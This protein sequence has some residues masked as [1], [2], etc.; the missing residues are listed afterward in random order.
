MADGAGL[1]TDDD[2]LAER[3]VLEVLREPGGN[4]P[5]ARGRAMGSSAKA[6]DAVVLRAAMLTAA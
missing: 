5:E 6:E 4:G 3:E 2:N 1:R